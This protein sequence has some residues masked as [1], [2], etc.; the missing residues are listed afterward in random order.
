[1]LLTSPQAENYSFEKT[2]LMT[3]VAS[4]QEVVIFHSLSIS[5]FDLCAAMG[6][7]WL[8][9]PQANRRRAA[10]QSSLAAG[11]PQGLKGM[12]MLVDLDVVCSHCKI[13]SRRPPFRPSLWTL[14][15]KKVRL[16]TFC[17]N[18]HLF[19]LAAVITTDIS[20]RLQSALDKSI[21][22]SKC[23]SRINMTFL[24]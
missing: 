1:M 9:L 10:C 7:A 8:Q 21:N 11:A 19:C 18:I 6:A 20:E 5:S 23:V 3:R 14:K 12:T 24:K 2:P 22:W 4:L 17:A 15:Q 16:V 13:S